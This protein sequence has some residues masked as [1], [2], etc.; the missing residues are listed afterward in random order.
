MTTIRRKYQIST[1]TP[2]AGRD[3]NDKGCQHEPS[4]ST[5]TPLAG[6]DWD[7]CP[8]RINSG[9]LLTRPLRDV[10]GLTPEEIME[11]KIS[12]H[13]PLAGRDQAQ[14]ALQERITDFYSHAPCGT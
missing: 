10:T 5:H 12:T 9:F 4:I 2:L 7:I 6:R 13:T 11:L 14:A 8:A 3:I 1:H